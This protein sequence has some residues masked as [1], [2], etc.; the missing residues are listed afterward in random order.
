MRS[1]Q[2][3]DITE[4][5]TER[6]LL[7]VGVSDL[8]AGRMDEDDRASFNVFRVRMMRKRRGRCVCWWHRSKG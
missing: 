4:E 7:Y 6:V 5:I 3:G 1:D 2:N 8:D